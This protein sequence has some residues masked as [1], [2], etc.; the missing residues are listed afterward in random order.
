MPL[1]S[2]G[3]ADKCS[4]EGMASCYHFSSEGQPDAPRGL[5]PQRL[6]ENLLETSA[7]VRGEMYG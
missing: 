5:M 2:G 4:F 6:L 1:G 3:K 7:R